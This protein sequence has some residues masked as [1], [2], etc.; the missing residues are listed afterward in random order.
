ME[1]EYNSKEICDMVL[2]ILD[3]HKAFDIKVLPVREKTVIAD[4]FVLCSGASSTQVKSLAGEI[5][6]KLSEKGI[7]PLHVDGRSDDNWRVLDYGCIM[8]HVFHQ[9]TRKFYNLEKLW[10]M[11][12]NSDNDDNVE[13]NDL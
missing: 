13:N 2:A 4:Y 5:E 9:S 3:E 1:K 7:K 10:D 8:V 6:F 11:A 12:K